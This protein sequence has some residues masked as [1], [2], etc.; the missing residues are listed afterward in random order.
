MKLKTLMALAVASAFALPLA[1]HAS[2]QGDS[3]LLAAGPSGANATGTGMSGGTPGT[4]SSGEPRAPTQGAVS[5]SASTGASGDFAS[6]DRNGDGRISRA[7]WDA[8]H[9]SSSGASAGGTTSRAPSGPG[10]DSQAGSGSDTATT[11]GTSGKG[12]AQ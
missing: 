3:I 7:E 6:L 10:T 2:A 4:H 1:A 12:K 9:R 11:P 5:S 8:H